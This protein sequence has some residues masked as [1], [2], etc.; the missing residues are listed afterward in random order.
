MAENSLP[1][2][3]LYFELKFR[4]CPHTAQIPLGHGADCIGALL[5]VSVCITVIVPSLGFC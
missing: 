1:N 3:P 5:R 2:R 4:D